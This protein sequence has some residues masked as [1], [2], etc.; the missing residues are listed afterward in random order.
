MNWTVNFLGG[1]IEVV[2][3][4]RWLIIG[5]GKNLRFLVLIRRGREN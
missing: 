1:L 4:I 2:G 3:L 5:L